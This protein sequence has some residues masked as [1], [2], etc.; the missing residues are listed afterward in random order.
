M[1]YGLLDDQFLYRGLLLGADTEFE[2]LATSGLRGFTARV[3]STELPRGDGSV[4]GPHYSASRQIALR[5]LVMGDVTARWAE[6]LDAFRI[7]RNEEFELAWKPPGQPEQAVWC[8]PVEVPNEEEAKGRGILES[9]YVRLEADD[10]RIY[11][12]DWQ[13]VQV[14]LYLASGGG[15]EIPHEIPTDFPD[16]T[17]GTTDAVAV[18]TGRDD[19]YPIVKFY[20]PLGSPATTVLLQNL[21]TGEELRIVT[22][23]VAPQILTFDAPAYATGRGGRVVDLDGASRYSAWQRPR[24]PFRLQ[25]GSNRLRFTCVGGNT[26]IGCQ[27][28]Y[29]STSL[30]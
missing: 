3:G 1:G 6:F 13:Q 14:P 20:A 5:F 21:D 18:N 4:P 15:V 25:S 7:N 12:A 28:I 19:A 24:T 9:V 2:T 11:E 10:P 29:R 16:G 17:G 23:I 30:S 8:R 22:P 26:N 27:V